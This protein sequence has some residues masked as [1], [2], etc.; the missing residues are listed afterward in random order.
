MSKRDYYSVL[1]IDKS[2]SSD[3]I[4]KAY[5]KMAVKYHPDK[6]SGNKSSEEKF[7]E[8]NEAYEV[9]SDDEKKALY[10]QFGHES[11]HSRSHS[12]FDG[13]QDVFSNFF[14]G[15]GG[16]QQQQRRDPSNPQRGADLRYEIEISLEESFFGCEKDMDI[17][18]LTP[19]EPCKNT[20]SEPGSK[21][22]QCQACNG[23][24][25]TVFS[26]GPFRMI[27]PC[28]PCK[29]FGK[30]VESPC[31][32]CG[33]NGRVQKP[34]K[35]KIKIPSGVE[36]GNQLCINDYGESGVHNGGNGNLYLLIRVK[37]HKIFR[38]EVNDLLCEATIL[39]TDAALG[40]EVE[41]PTLTGKT[42]INVA[43]GTQ[44]DSELR[45]KGLGMPNPQTGRTG[46]LRVKLKIG[47]PTNLTDAQKLKLKEF[48]S[49]CK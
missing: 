16:H 49:L 1:E 33:G 3:D 31:K 19:C 25:H 34:S 46:D 20:G 5:R 27:Q 24:G 18:K 7:K 43:S 23:N 22:K 29:G 12:S 32:S 11:P 26:Q 41:M 38:R 42:K 6:N 48:A 17:V 36:T 15:F 9:L 14:G 21:Y 39:F 45:V 30:V 4:K 13:F 8:V 37:E 35:I 40:N 2:A 44:Q 28:Q 47:V 10:D